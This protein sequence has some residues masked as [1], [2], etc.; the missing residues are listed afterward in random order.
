MNR[1]SALHDESLQRLLASAFAVQEHRDLASRHSD[2]LEPTVI[3]APQPLLPEAFGEI[4][5][6]QEKEE[7]NFVP[8]PEFLML[9]QNRHSLYA[10][11]GA[12]LS[13]TM[14]L[15]GFRYLVRLVTTLARR[16]KI[17]APHNPKPDSVPLPATPEVLPEVAREVKILNSRSQNFNFAPA[18]VVA[19]LVRRTK[20]F[21]LLMRR[22]KDL[23]WSIRW[24][25]LS[26]TTFVSRLAHRARNPRETGLWRNFAPAVAVALRRRVKKL[27]WPDR[28]RNSAPASIGP[29]FAQPSEKR[30]KT[31]GWSNWRLNFVPVRIVS[32]FAQRAQ[33]LD[34]SKL[35]RHSGTSA[36]VAVVLTFTLLM[37]YEVRNPVKMGSVASPAANATEQRSSISK[38]LQENPVPVAETASGSPR[39]IRPA[40]TAPTTHP[41]RARVGSNEVRSMG[42]DVTVR[43]F[44]DRRATKR[45]GEPNSGIAH[46]GDD[47]TVRYFAPPPP[48][49]TATR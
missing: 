8:P 2:Q 41:G 35:R 17:V 36:V 1:R 24:R 37:V 38:P 47:V 39:S 25:N 46:I 30:K 15:L 10:R 12:V 31:F 7:E 6:R 26:P 40:K 11:C 33:N 48:A 13:D 32:A 34:W 29:C 16:A 4:T 42:D 9:P 23:N 14:D 5:G 20:N 44:T 49:R 28:W 45:S 22:A 21:A 27:D 18:T 43:T 19:A 3:L